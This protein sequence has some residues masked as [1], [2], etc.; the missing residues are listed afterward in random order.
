MNNKSYLKIIGSK[1][2]FFQKYFKVFRLLVIIIYLSYLALLII[3]VF[4]SLEYVPTVDE[5]KA[6]F[7]PIK[8]KN[9]IISSIED[10]FSAKQDNLEKNL[11]KTREHNPFLPYEKE[12]LDN[13]NN[14]D[15][16]EI[17]IV[18]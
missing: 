17:N 18:N 12:G 15:N 10:Y 8:A 11:L 9:E 4:S 5:V 1:L 6:K 3:N 7:S 13:V 2:G 14:I 16:P